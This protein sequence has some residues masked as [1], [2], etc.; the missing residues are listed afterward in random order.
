M[1]KSI[2]E[3]REIVKGLQWFGCDKRLGSPDYLPEEVAES[4]LAA[5]DD[6]ERYGMLQKLAKREPCE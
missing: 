4:F 6:A 5:L 2:K 1:A 3:L